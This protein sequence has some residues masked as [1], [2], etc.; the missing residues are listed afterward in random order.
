MSDACLMVLVVSSVLRTLCADLEQIVRSPCFYTLR[1]R[2]REDIVVNNL[3]KEPESKKD[4]KAK[5]VVLEANPEQHSR[6][7]RFQNLQGMVD[8]LIPLPKPVKRLL[9]R[10][11]IR[12]ANDGT[13]LILF[14]RRQFDA[15]VGAIRAGIT[16]AREYEGLFMD[17]DRQRQQER[18]EPDL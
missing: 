12:L 17:Q 7:L 11:L 14:V 18:R 16:E 6:E 15:I 1:Y 9:G 5:A 2:F 13:E 8:V 10:I 4:E 3:Y